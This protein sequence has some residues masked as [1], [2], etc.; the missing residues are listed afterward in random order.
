M[1]YSLCN[2]PADEPICLLASSPGLLFSRTTS[3]ICFPFS[4][5]CQSQSPNVKLHP[6]SPTW[7]QLFSKTFI[8]PYPSELPPNLIHTT[9]IFILLLNCN[10]F[11]VPFH[12]FG[13]EA[14]NPYHKINACINYSLALNTLHLQKVNEMCF[15]S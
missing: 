14:F 7:C 5:I 1:F 8:S 2:L 4:T 3:I 15:S 9:A 12:S 11:P 13:F 6:A 10:F